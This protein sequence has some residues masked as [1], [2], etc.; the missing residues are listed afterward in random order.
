MLFTSSAWLIFNMIGHLSKIEIVYSVNVLLLHIDSSAASHACFYLLLKVG[1]KWLGLVLPGHNCL[2]LSNFCRLQE[3][4]CIIIKLS[5]VE[6]WFSQFC[7]NMMESCCCSLV[8]SPSVVILSTKVGYF[9]LL[10][11]VL[12]YNSCVIHL[13]LFFVCIRFGNCASGF[14]S[15][16]PFIVLPW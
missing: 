16:S 11:N 9:D 4:M 7:N 12:T 15:I 1:E 8:D 5:F 13:N 10:H 14:G 3:G 6:N 2:S